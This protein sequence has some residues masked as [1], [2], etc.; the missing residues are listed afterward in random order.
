MSENS[1]HISTRIDRP[2]SEVYGLRRGPGQPTEM[3]EWPWDLGRARRRTVDR[4]ISDGP[5]LARLRAAQRIRHPRS[6]GHT[7]GPA[8]AGA[9]QLL[10]QR[11]QPVSSVHSRKGDRDGDRLLSPAGAQAG[12]MTDIALF[13]SSLGVR[14]GIIDAADRLR[15]AGHRV[16]VVDQYDGQV[17]DDYDQADRFVEQVGFP[18]LMRRAV[19]AVQDLPDGFF[20]AGF[21]N[22]GGMAEY[23]ATQRACSGVL[24]LSGALPVQMLGAAAWP[25]GVP[26]QIHYTQHDPRRRQE[27]I[28]TLVAS[29]RAASASAQVFDYPGSGH[30]FTDP[31]IPGEYDEQAAALLWHRALAF[32]RSP[33]D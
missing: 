31:S 28:D 26:A 22:G 9:A 10:G 29:V 4:R 14:P 20:A 33:H 8:G 7:A 19:E 18:E 17:F 2:G 16:L 13:H 23:T 30:L 32:C 1:R 25:T 12:R 15:G 6:L 27:W 11:V 21:S 24:L 5:R 3:G